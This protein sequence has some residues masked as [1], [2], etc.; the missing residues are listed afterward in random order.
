MSA[1]VVH[2]PT[3][4][5]ETPESHPG[6]EQVSI[7]VHFW[8]INHHELHSSLSNASQDPLLSFVVGHLY[9]PKPSNVLHN[10]LPRCPKHYWPSTEVYSGFSGRHTSIKKSSDHAWLG[11]KNVLCFE[12]MPDRKKRDYLFWT[13]LQLSWATDFGL[14]TS[15]TVP[16]KSSQED[17]SEPPICLFVALY[18]PTQSSVVGLLFKRQRS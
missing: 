15:V 8:S 13:T 2:R 11:R 12:S 5:C 17:S 6:S 16:A 9:T 18:F 1:L 14:V 3:W 10:R 7:L 4:T